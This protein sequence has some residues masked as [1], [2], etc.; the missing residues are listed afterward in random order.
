DTFEYSSAPIHKPHKTESEKVKERYN[1]VV[2]SLE[3]IKDNAQESFSAQCKKNGFLSKSY[4]GIKALWFSNNREKLVKKDIDTYNEQ[5]DE[6]SKS[7]EKGKFTKTFKKIFG[8]PYNQENIDKFNKANERLMLASTTKYVADTIEKTIGEDFKIA[9]KNKGELKGYVDNKFLPYAPTGSIPVVET[10]LDKDKIFSKMEASLSKAVGG[11]EVLRGMLKTQQIEED[12][13]KEDKYKAYYSIADFLLKTSKKTSEKWSNGKSIKELTKD[14]NDAYETAFGRENNIQKRVDCYNRSQQ[15]GLSMLKAG[16]KN[17]MKLAIVAITGISNPLAIIPAGVALDFGMDML[18]KSTNS[19]KKDEE[20]SAKTMKQLAKDT[21][22]DYADYLIDAGFSAVVPNFETGNVILN[23]MLSGA[24]KTTIDVTTSMITE[25]MDTGK[26]DKTQIAPRAF[27]AAVFGKISPDD[28]LAKDLLA[29]T[30]NGVKK[31]LL[32]DD[33]EK[34][35]VKQFIN[36]LQT[37]LQEEYMKNPE[38]YSAMKTVSM[39]DPKIFEDMIVDILQEQIDEK[40]KSK[41]G[42]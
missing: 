22:I 27:V 8:L 16:I 24:R 34:N 39:S 3:L 1:D 5:L 10:Y 14:Y 36:K 29:M 4:D 41:N 6:L 9:V 12:A 25:Y 20:I 37:E 11:N 17:P 18:E 31:S 26:W 19:D 30:Q 40:S 28:E 32:Y 15:I 21:A 23:G 35:S 2:K 42:K 33:S 7:V 13:S 38:M